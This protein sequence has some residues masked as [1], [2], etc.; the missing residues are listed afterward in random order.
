[1]LVIR[2]GPDTTGTLGQDAARTAEFWAL[3]GVPLLSISVF[4][5]LGMPLDQLLRDRFSKFSVIHRLQASY[6]EEF[7]LLPT[8]RSPHFTVRLRQANEEELSR[9][10]AAL[11]API[12][13]PEYHEVADDQREAG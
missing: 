12:L 1:M 8:F 4:A 7:Q 6:L 9:L 3:E 2:G 10:L 11:G 13:N 5:V